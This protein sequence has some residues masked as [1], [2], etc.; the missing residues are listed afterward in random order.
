MR[1]S[2]GTSPTNV[3]TTKHIFVNGILSIQINDLTIII[4]DSTF[5]LCLVS[6][7]VKSICMNSL[8]G[9]TFPISFTECAEN[10]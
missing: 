8:C 9:L 1:G 7:S 3:Q 10:P 2:D 5:G 4:L 6:L